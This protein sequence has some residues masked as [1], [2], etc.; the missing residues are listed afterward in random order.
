MVLTMDERKNSGNYRN[1]E[2][3]AKEQAYQEY[4]RLRE[5]RNGRGNYIKDDTLYGAYFKNS[6][7]NG[8]DNTP[9]G[10]S[11]MRRESRQRA[12]NE[13]YLR[14]RDERHSGKKKPVARQG[15][16]NKADKLTRAEKKTL[17]KLEK[18]VW[19]FPEEMAEA[20]KNTEEKKAEVLRLL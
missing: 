1:N 5:D 9:Y 18:T 11:K 16:V 6:S 3:K 19:L 15:S 4:L 8:I 13:Q 17:R 10:A 7:G 20:A 2:N 14:E 12:E